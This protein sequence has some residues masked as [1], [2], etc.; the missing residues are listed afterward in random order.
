MSKTTDANQPEQ[1]A[2]PY[3]ELLQLFEEARQL[4]IQSTHLLAV[5]RQASGDVP[6]AY[7]GP[8]ARTSTDAPL[9]P[10]ETLDNIIML[11]TACSFEWQ[12]HIVKSLALA[13]ASEAR[14]RANIKRPST[15]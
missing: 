14:A 7:A 13:I 9:S 5:A 12:V 8:E 2:Q 6:A 11:L 10:E 3:T 1:I 15:A 4:Q